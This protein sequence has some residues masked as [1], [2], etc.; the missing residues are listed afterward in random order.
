[1]A[2]LGAGLFA[3]AVVS[4]GFGAP[5]PGQMVGAD[6]RLTFL[7]TPLFAAPLAAYAV[8]TRRM[9]LW[10]AIGLVA[11]LT[12]I[13]GASQVAAGM[14]YLNP[15]PSPSQRILDTEADRTFRSENRAEM[16]VAARNTSIRAGLVGGALGGGLAVLLAGFVLRRG[17]VP[18]GDI[19]LVLLLAAWPAFAL[20]DLAL[21]PLTAHLPHAKPP[22]EWAF[23]VFLPW[24]LAFGAW[25][26]VALRGAAQSGR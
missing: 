12:V 20:S 7:F 26:A 18:I 11:G 3:L 9:G 23:R 1:M 24:Q 8:W 5:P 6:P 19:A 22:W 2:A 13:H 10:R 4:G 25:M 21:G 17:G 14:N 15:E 16:I